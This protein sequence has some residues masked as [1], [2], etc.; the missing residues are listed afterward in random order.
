MD[1]DNQIDPAVMDQP[2][3]A[4]EFPLGVGTATEPYPTNAPWL[5]L[6]P[7]KK[8]NRLSRWPR[9][10]KSPSWFKKLATCPKQHAERYRHRKKDPSGLD[11][12]IGN[13]IHGAYEDAGMIRMKPGRRGAVNPVVTP[14]ELIHLLEF[15]EEIREGVEVY[16]RSRDI[17]QNTKPFS[18]DN[19]Y[20]VEH[21]WNFYVTP[22]L[23]VAGFADLIQAVPHPTNPSLP[24]VMIVVSDYKTG[25]GQLPSPEELETDPQCQLELAW[26][27]RKFPQTPRIRFRIV[28]VQLN[29]EVWCD[30]TPHHHERALGF[31]RALSNRWHSRDETAVVGNHCKWCPYRA[32][33]SA[34][35]KSLKKITFTPLS[36]LDDLSLEDM[37]REWKTMKLA[38]DL[39]ERRRIDLGNKIMEQIP[40]DQRSYRVNHLLAMKKSRKVT[41]YA[42]T[43]E[44]VNDLTSLT[45][46]VPDA[47]I[48]SVTKI[49]KKQLENWIKTLPD[50]LQKPA[51]IILEKHAIESETSPW[52]EVHDRK[53][54]W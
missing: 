44:L 31:A 28:N 53:P 49:R 16:N 5:S 1:D 41:N 20:D 25:L 51:M 38:Q 6:P 15:Q 36:E 43:A 9:G 8:I 45:G 42:S 24:P 11:A 7:P 13:A 4:E 35:E 54:L 3:E 34:F 47:L 21:L 2:T 50:H 12:L 40:S 23:Q 37:I 14:E 46:T 48:D 26:A 29:K 33:C 19:I 52:L 10:A 39:T 22:S 30:W 32:G 17:L 27:R 18:L